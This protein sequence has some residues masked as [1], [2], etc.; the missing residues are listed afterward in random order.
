MGW[1]GFLFRATYELRRKSGLLRSGYPTKVKTEKFSDL[2][3]WKKIME[4]FSSIQKRIL[5]KLMY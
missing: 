3:G 1:K 4:S 5:R 2:A